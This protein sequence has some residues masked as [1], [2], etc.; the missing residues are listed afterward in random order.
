MQLAVTDLRDF[1]LRPLGQIVRRLLLARI[2]ARW[3][4]VEGETLIGLG[5]TSPYLG[6]FRGE[7][8]RIG[9]FMPAGQGAL[10]WPSSGPSQSV[11]VEEERLP[12]PDS[13]VNRLLAVHCLEAAE[14][15]RPL[16]RE[17]WRVLAPEGR[18]LM[19]VPNRSGVWA[20]FDTTP[21]GQGRPYSRG[22][23]GRLLDE[24]LFTPI[25]WTNALYVPP[26]DRQIILKSATAFERLGSRLSPRFSGVII[27]EAR[28]EL[29]APV[30]KAVPASRLGGLVPVRAGGMAL[31]AEDA[32]GNGRGA[33]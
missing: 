18:L 15:V 23:L 27:V 10:V 33:R 30:G 14:R 1:Y 11:L 28:K 31:S 25:D 29:M 5:F 3:R 20:R 16:L 4:H 7:A 13:S 17:M 6:A 24:A 32:A 21:F 19:V 2:R 9:A 22:Q 26:I 12:L 8:E